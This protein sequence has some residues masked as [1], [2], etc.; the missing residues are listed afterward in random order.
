M[1]PGF[2]VPVRGPSFS[3][4]TLHLDGPLRRGRPDPWPWFRGRKF[5]QREI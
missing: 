2:T 4:V 5:R 1:L 3:G